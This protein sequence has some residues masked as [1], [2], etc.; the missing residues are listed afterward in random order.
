MRGLSAGERLRQRAEVFGLSHLPTLTHTVNLDS[1]VYY[2]GRFWGTYPEVREVLN[3]RATGCHGTAWYQHLAETAGGTFTRALILNCGNGWV[4]RELIRSDVI[5]EAVGIDV[6][7]ELVKTA[8]DEA[9]SNGLPLRYVVLDANTAAFPVDDFD[10][11]V[12]YAAAHHIAYLD[13]VFRHLHSLLAPDGWFVSWDYVGP[14]RAQYPVDQVAAAHAVNLELPPSARSDLYYPRLRTMLAM[15]PTEAIHSELILEVMARYFHMDVHPLGGAIAY[16]LLTHNESL[17]RLPPAD[18]D[19]AVSHVMAADQVYL[20]DHPESSLFAYVIARPRAG[21]LDDRARLEAW[22]AE[23]EERERRAAEQGGEYYPRT[24]LAFFAE[25]LAEVEV[26]RDHAV[27]ALE[28]LQ[29]A[30]NLREGLRRVLFPIPG[31]WPLVKWLQSR[32]FPNS[33]DRRGGL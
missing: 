6:S 24:V 16:L 31:V 10:L 25:R 22:T 7:T 5:R 28:S 21:A 3:R 17:P 14:H 11:I 26:A 32:W 12:N 15:D 2:R 18:V 13:R 20:D 8:R 33:S 30:V 23:E 27:S 1:S 19:A 4:E 9:A 29:W